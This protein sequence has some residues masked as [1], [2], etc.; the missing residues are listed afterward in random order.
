MRGRHAASGRAGRALASG[1]VK[2]RGRPAGDGWRFGETTEGVALSS[3]WEIAR[4]TGRCAVSGRELA[5]G[6][7]YYAVLLETAAGL[8]RRDYSIEAWSGAPEGT[9]CHWRG[10]M[11]TKQKRSGPISLDPELLTQLFLRLEESGV[12]AMQQLRFVIGLLLMRKRLVRMEQTTQQEGREF[13]QL[14]LVQDG[15]IH[16]VPNPQLS[17]E[18]VDRLS[19]QLLG[20]LSGE[21]DAVTLIED[22]PSAEARSEAI[23]G[24]ADGVVSDAASDT[25]PDEASDDLT[26]T[27]TQ[28]DD[29]TNDDPPETERQEN[30]ATS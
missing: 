10:R 6:E 9:F 16:Q 25:S 27:G 26:T 14:R 11:P 23:S 24:A 30:L 3:E 28:G 20:L 7:S 2:K 18:Q 8:E 29:S 5:E 1:W 15:S 4:L 12:E 13:W 17:N 22:A 21:L 19:I